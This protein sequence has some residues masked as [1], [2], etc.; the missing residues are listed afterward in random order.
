[1]RY[2]K[3]VLAVTGLFILFAIVG[4]ATGLFGSDP[5]KESA[6]NAFRVAFIIAAVFTWRAATKRG[7][8]VPGD[9]IPSLLEKAAQEQKKI[10]TRHSNE[11]SELE[12]LERRVPELR[13]SLLRIADSEQR[14]RDFQPSLDGKFRCPRCWIA[15]GVYRDLVQD[16]PEGALRLKCEAPGCNVRL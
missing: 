10:A 15:D 2:L 12:Y 6:K 4:Y 14:L 5:S 13:A 8:A 3:A 7:K 16:G 9:L 1:M 11:A